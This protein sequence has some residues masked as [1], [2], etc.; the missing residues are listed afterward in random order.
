MPETL[1]L[2]KLESLLASMRIDPLG[3]WY[4]EYLEALHKAGPALI[5]AARERDQLQARI[6]RIIG[7]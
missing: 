5:T 1:D 2:D 7:T 6:A 4:G 3:P